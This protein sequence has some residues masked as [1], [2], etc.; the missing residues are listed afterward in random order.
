[1]AWNENKTGA[2]EEAQA[3][4]EKTNGKREGMSRLKSRAENRAVAF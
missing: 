2:F 4:K 3:R 1:M